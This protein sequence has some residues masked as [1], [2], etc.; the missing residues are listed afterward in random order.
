MHDQ[1]I[2]NILLCVEE[3]TF[4]LKK[5]R[6]RISFTATLSRLATDSAKWCF[7]EEKSLFLRYIARRTFGGNALPQ[8]QDLSD[9]PNPYEIRW[10]YLPNQFF[11]GG[12][13]KGKYWWPGLP[14]AVPDNIVMHH[15]NFTFSIKNKVMQLTYVKEN[16]EER[17]ANGISST[18]K[19]NVKAF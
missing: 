2:I 6:C 1:T 12:T 9:T 7:G 13:L 19:S 16:V 15:A 10:G 8:A 17:S 14:L 3:N 4:S 11:G 18:A 5:N